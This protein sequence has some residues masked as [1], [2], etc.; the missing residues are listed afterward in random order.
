MYVAEKF[1]NASGHAGSCQ[2]C[3]DPGT[4]LYSWGEPGSVGSMTYY[5]SDCAY[6]LGFTFEHNS[7]MTGVYAEKGGEG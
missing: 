4:V 6:E 1:G 2:E 3:G 7:R 5:C